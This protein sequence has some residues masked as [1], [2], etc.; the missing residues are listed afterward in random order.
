MRANWANIEKAKK[1][2]DW[3][4]RVGLLEGIAN[5]VDWY[6]TEHSWTRLVDTE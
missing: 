4:P 5:L 6:R 1:L 2:L 3:E